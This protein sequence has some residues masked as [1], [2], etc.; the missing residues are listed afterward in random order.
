MS[1][2]L[3]DHRS[4]AGVADFAM[5]VL[6][7]SRANVLGC[8]PAKSGSSD[9]PAKAPGQVLDIILSVAGSRRLYQR[10]IAIKL[11]RVCEEVKDGFN[12]LWRP[13]DAAAAQSAV[14][15]FAFTVFVQSYNATDFVRLR[16]HLMICSQTESLVMS[17]GITTNPGIA[18]R[19]IGI[20]ILRERTMAALEKSPDAEGSQ[21]V[22][23]SYTY[24]TNILHIQA[25]FVP[26]TTAHHILQ[27]PL[28]ALLLV[29]LNLITNLKRLPPVEAHTAL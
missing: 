4:K 17:L 23:P 8:V 28:L 27:G 14:Q 10:G 29:R 12:L 16:I 21:G 19:D 18:R 11:S 13:P 9:L 1:D 6:E 3:D 24:H 26:I 25:S 5:D 22:F 7:S 20:G 15:L 2:N